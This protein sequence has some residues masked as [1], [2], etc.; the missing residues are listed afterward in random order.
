MENCPKC[1]ALLEVIECCGG[2]IFRCESCGE[3]YFY[4]ELIESQRGFEEVSSEAQEQSP[5]EEVL[6]PQPCRPQCL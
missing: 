5:L 2:G 4:G 3:Y 1:G 6:P